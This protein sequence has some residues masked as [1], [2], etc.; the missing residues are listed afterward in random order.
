MFNKHKS[1]WSVFIS[2]MTCK[3]LKGLFVD[4]ADGWK[5]RYGWMFGCTDGL[6]ITGSVESASV[7]SVIETPNNI[8]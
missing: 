1:F 8:L 5:V 6:Y 2:I 4:Q 3:S 7:N